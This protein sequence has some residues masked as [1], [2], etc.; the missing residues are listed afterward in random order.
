MD[1]RTNASS[2]T[3]SPVISLISVAEVGTIDRAEFVVYKPLGFELIRIRILGLIVVN[4]VCVGNDG[5]ALRN[6]VT[7]VDVI[8]SSG[9]WNS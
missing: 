9:M 5:S 4:C 2:S 1:P 6:T 3:V 7:F 8:P